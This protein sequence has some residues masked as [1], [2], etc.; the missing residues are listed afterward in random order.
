VGVAGETTGS[1]NSIRFPL[2]WSDRRNPV[3][4]IETWQLVLAAGNEP[5]ESRVLVAA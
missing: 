3:T 2:R 1:G 4:S 5:F